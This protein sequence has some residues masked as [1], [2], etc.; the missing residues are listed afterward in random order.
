VIQI[1]S[2]WANQFVLARKSAIR[3]ICLM[4]LC[5]AVSQSYICNLLYQTVKPTS[6]DDGV[7]YTRLQLIH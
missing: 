5:P 3:F 4:W 6:H 2:F 7:D 1:D